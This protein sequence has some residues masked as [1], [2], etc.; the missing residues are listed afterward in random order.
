MI[1]FRIGE[2]AKLIDKSPQT[3]R[4][5]DKQGIL[6][7]AVI[8]PEGKKLYSKQQLDEFLQ[9]QHKKIIGYCR[10][11]A[12]NQIDDLDEQVNQMKSYLDEHGYEYEIIS[13][14]GSGLK[15]TRK[16]LN[17]LLHLITEKKVGKIV[18]LKRD[19]LVRYGMEM[20][21][22][23][24]RSFSC[25]VEYVLDDVNEDDYSSDIAN[26]IRNFEVQ[27]DSKKT[28][29]AKRRIKLLLKEGE[30][31]DEIRFEETLSRREEG[32]TAAA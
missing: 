15:Y 27:L 25:D 16:G 20:I 17:D 10:V 14:V 22:A 23:V 12:Y 30:E 4:N 2:F 31:E 29:K 3:L 6:K 21:E 32:E 24:C 19:S 26:I 13:E 18:M 11:N 5:W 1:Y 9:R 8:S 28:R 7:P